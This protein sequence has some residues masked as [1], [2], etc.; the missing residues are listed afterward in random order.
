MTLIKNKEKFGNTVSEFLDLMFTRALDNGYGQIE[1]KL[2]K[3]GAIQS[4]FHSMYNTFIDA[5]YDGCNNG[6]NVYFGVNP[7]TGGA[8]KKENVHFLTSFHAEVDYGKAGHKKKPD[9]LTYEEALGAIQGYD[10]PPTIINHSGGGFH[11]YWV[12]N[13]A[14]EVKKHGVDILENINKG[15]TKDL[16]ADAGTHHLAMV[17]RIPDTFNQKLPGNPRKVTIITMAGPRYKFEDFQKFLK[18]EPHPCYIAFIN[19]QMLTF[20]EVDRLLSIPCST[21]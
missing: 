12:L 16:K 21:I 14:V 17:L 8:G 10:L 3:N 9:Y 20:W 19:R 13:N 7:R 2:I 1:L 18:P 15:L 11:C 6:W 4:T 5:A